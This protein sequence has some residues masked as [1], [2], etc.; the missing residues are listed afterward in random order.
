MA[1][2]IPLGL[3]WSRTS[4]T[5]VLRTFVPAAGPQYSIAFRGGHAKLLFQRVRVAQRT[6]ST[7]DSQYSTGLVRK[8]AHWFYGSSLLVVLFAER[9]GW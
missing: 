5:L 6:D 1:I 7:P 4:E 3:D 9:D 8:V 2:Y